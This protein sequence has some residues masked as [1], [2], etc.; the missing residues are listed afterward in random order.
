MYRFIL[1]LLACGLVACGG[2][3]TAPQQVGVAGRWIYRVNQLSDGGAV[4]C[5]MIDADTLTLDRSTERIAGTFTGGDISCRNGDDVETIAMVTGSVV[6][7]TVEPVASGAQ[8]VTFDLGG[9]YWH[10]TGSLTGDRMSGTLTV[11]HG[12]TGRLGNMHL[13]GSWS[14]IRTSLITHRH[15]K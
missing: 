6:N 5:T 2:D 4:A 11:D 7:G 3:S 15:P 9:A 1:V 12:F 14:A 10:Q 13:T 8:S